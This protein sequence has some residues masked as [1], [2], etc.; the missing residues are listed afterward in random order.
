MPF[1]MHKNHIFSRKKEKEI[2]VPTLRK[3]SRPFTRN[4]LIFLFG[5]IGHIFTLNVMQMNEGTVYKDF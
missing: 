2:C 4:T 1:K 3:I 5:F